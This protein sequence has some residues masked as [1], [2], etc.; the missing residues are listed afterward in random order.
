[1]AKS[2]YRGVWTFAEQRGGILEPVSFELLGEG[3]RLADQAG[4]ELAAVL[5]GH[6]VEDLAPVLMA[7]GADVVYLA[8]APSL[9]Y[10]VCHWWA[11]VV[12]DMIRRHRPD[13]FILGSTPIGS[14]LA[15]RVAAAVETGL[16]SHCTALRLGENGVLDQVV[17]AFGG[18]VMATV[19]CPYKRPQMVTVMPGVL[20]EGPL[21]AGR[22]GRLERVPVEE[23]AKAGE[24]N[25]PSFP[26]LLEQI[27]FCPDAR[28]VPLEKAERV[29]AG[30]FGIGGSEGWKLLE[31]LAELLG[32]EVGATRPPADEGW[33][34]MGR[35]IGQSGKVVRPGLYIGVGISGYMQHTVGIQESGIV[36]AINSDPRAP[37]F[38]A[39]DYGIVGDYKKILPALIAVLEEAKRRKA[40]Q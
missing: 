1:M 27:Q 3:R 16:S 37:I 40:P 18:N 38:E 24:H 30:G 13:I 33:T 34:T 15:A 21:Q 9:C 8:D 10:F 19:V 39:A 20:K 35:M 23:Q 28:G 4:V 5:L 31:R 14:E 11:R 7:R 25:Q 29:V 36:I 22:K 2:D 12:A 32:A 17:P 6:Q 26:R